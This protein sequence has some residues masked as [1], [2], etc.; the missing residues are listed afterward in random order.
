MVT[1]ETPLAVEMRCAISVSAYSST[2]Y[3]GSVSDLSASNNTGCSAG[4]DFWYDGGRGISGGSVPPALAM[5]AWTSCAAASMLRSSANV[6]VIDVLP[7]EFD[8]LIESIPEIV[9]NCLSRGVATADAIVS[10]VAPGKAA[11]TCTVGKSTVGKAA[12]G[13][14]R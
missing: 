11:F 1:C 7:C 6:I 3:K 9:E 12:T 10:G 2:V 4:L 13:R 8:E 14:L 5:A